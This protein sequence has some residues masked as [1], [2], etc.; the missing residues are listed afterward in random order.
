MNEFMR[1]LRSTQKNGLEI[2][3]RTVAVAFATYC[4]GDRD[5]RRAMQARRAPELRR[6]TRHRIG[7]RIGSIL[8]KP[9]T[10][11]VILVQLLALGVSA[12]GLGCDIARNESI[13][14]I[15]APRLSFLAVGDT[16]R[17]RILPSLF[18][19]Q[20]S[21]SEAMTDE[22][23]RDS[24]DA[25]VFLGDN[26]M[27]VPNG[28]VKSEKSSRFGLLR[29]FTTVSTDVSSSLSNKKRPSVVRATTRL[30]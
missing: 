10:R 25:L 11:G 16:G 28:I 26:F 27:M 6:M 30:P 18:E 21:V 20:R 22:A 2:S 17:T 7:W 4:A 3:L 14:P 15:D 23:R 13:A 5:L 9:M 1:L 8:G 19:G 24:V 12:F 29:H